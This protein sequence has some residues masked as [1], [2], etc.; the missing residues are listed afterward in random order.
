MVNFFWT[1]SSL[2]SA[3]MR[4]LK[5]EII[6]TIAAG[7]P[8]ETRANSKKL[9]REPELKKSA[10]H[11]DG[12]YTTP[13][14]LATLKTVSRKLST[15]PGTNLSALKDT[16]KIKNRYATIKKRPKT[17]PMTIPKFLKCSFAARAATAKAKRIA[18]E[19]ARLGPR[20]SANKAPIK[21]GSVTASKVK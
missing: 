20:R 11:S 2:T 4:S 15:T 12:R 9:T 7:A 18:A 19:T 8:K 10:I 16:V 13:T 17:P 3:L 6:A 5:R 14:E 1:L 21:R